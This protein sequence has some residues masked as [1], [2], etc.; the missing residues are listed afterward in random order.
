MWDLIESRILLLYPWWYRLIASYQSPSGHPIFL[1][2]RLSPCWL[3]SW[4]GCTSLGVLHHQAWQ[5]YLVALQWVASWL[6]SWACCLHGLFE[7]CLKCLWPSQDHWLYQTHLFPMRIEGPSTPKHCDE[8]VG[9]AQNLVLRPYSES[10]H[11]HTQCSKRSY[12]AR[13]DA[14]SSSNSIWYSPSHRN[15]GGEGLPTGT[16]VKVLKLGKLS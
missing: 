14:S 5:I 1:N 8:F 11:L 13:L 4:A 10:Q 3:A 12:W 2:H 15:G 6:S 9:V 7:E 16:K